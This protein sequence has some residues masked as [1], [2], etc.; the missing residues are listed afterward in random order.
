MPSTASLYSQV[1]GKSCYW[2]NFTFSLFPRG[3]PDILHVTPVSQLH[4][5]IIDKELFWY[6]WK[7]FL[8]VTRCIY[9]PF[10]M[11]IGPIGNQVS[12]KGNSTGSTKINGHHQDSKTSTM[13][14]KSER[15]NSPNT[16]KWEP[17]VRM[18]MT[19]SQWLKVVIL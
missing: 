3:W 12:K 4:Y 7:C 18:M 11:S 8:T 17:D 15:L 6:I 19:T 1:P 16:S 2:W 10:Y 14:S 13:P 5:D 9:V